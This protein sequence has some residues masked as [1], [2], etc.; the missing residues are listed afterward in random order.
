MTDA[1]TATKKVQ[2]I[3]ADAQKSFSEG[4]EKFSKGL[5]NAASF[6]QENVD[7]VVKSSGIA[8]K[9]AEEMGA[10]MMA[11]AKKS[12]EDSMAA[13]KEL[14]GVKS[15]SEFVEKQTQF[16]QTSFNGFFTEVSKLNEMYLAAAKNAVEPIGARFT[17]AAEA[18]RSYQA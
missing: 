7:A 14:S 5:E 9:A 17:A 8:A 16:A 3:A 6:G 11:F 12:A 10:E 15:V 2:T 18:V 4:F 1:K 13:A